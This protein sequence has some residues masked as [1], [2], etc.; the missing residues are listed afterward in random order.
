MEQKVISSQGIKIK[1]AKKDFVLLHGLFGDL[2]NWSAFEDYFRPFH[3]VH[4]PQLPLYKKSGKE[5]TL[6]HFVTFLEDYITENN[7]QHPVLVGNSLGGHIALL[8]TIKH[9]EKVDKLI[10]TG[11]SGLYESTLDVPFPRINDFDFISDKVREVFYNQESVTDALIKQVFN[12]IQDRD[13]ALS[14]VRTAKAAR[15]QNLKDALN[16]I[17]LPVLLIWGMQ[18][19][20]T[21]T[22]VAEEFY[23]L[24]PNSHLFLI[25][26]CGHAPMMEQPEEFNN[27]VAEF[28]S[29]SA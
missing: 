11:S 23:Y 4:T 25:N 22:N 26:N 5:S 14:V 13:K 20:V 29:L 18:D 9:P 3:N 6:D 28:I 1:Q 27:K 7:I 24:L 10:L 21:P 19:I 2:S 16:T 17:N 12:T 15:N 8:Y